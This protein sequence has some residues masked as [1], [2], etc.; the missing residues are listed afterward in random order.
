MNKNNALS[1][2]KNVPV[3]VLLLS[4]SSLLLFVCLFGCWLLVFVVVAVVVACLQPN[5]KD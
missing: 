2:A 1:P 3:C 4:L 5:H